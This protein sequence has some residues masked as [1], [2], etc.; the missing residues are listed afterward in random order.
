[1]KRKIQEILL[2]IDLFVFMPGVAG[3]LEN[4]G[5]ALPFCIQLVIGLALATYLTPMER[6]RN[7]NES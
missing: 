2:I 6:R 5:K 7:N 4:G 3:Y 1:M